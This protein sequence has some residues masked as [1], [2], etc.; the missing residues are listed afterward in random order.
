[1]VC[2]EAVPVAA[3]DANAILSPDPGCCEEREHRAWEIT[4]SPYV[5]HIA[6]TQSADDVGRAALEHL[7]CEGFDKRA[8]LLREGGAG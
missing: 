8:T 7:T 5:N 6:T 1:V 2:T 3:T 4:M